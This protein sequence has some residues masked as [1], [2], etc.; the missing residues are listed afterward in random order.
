M[1]AHAHDADVWRIAAILLD[2]YGVRTV[3]E[4]MAEASRARAALADSGDAAPS[5]GP[6]G[7]LWGEVFDALYELL[8]PLPE[9]GD[10]VH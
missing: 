4:A 2:T 3:T 10:H 7:G 5:G 1:D 8:K 9:A 6:T